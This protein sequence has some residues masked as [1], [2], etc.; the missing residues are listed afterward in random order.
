MIG[1]IF[2]IISLLVLLGVFG[3]KLWNILNFQKGGVYPK[4]HY[5]VFMIMG[6]CLAV[7][8]WV[9]YFTGYMSLISYEQT[10]NV[11]GEIIVIANNAYII[12]NHVFTIVNIL[13]WASFGI[14]L[15]EFIMYAG[16]VVLPKNYRWW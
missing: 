6:L 2:C 13:L 16:M 1:E 10:M 3:A 5:K 9:F 11:G 7:M 12:F 4:E 15:I 8:A 14:T